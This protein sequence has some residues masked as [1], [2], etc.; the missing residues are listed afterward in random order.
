MNQNRCKKRHLD[1][2]GSIQ[3]TIGHSIQKSSR[4]TVRFGE[5]F[6]SS[7]PPRGSQKLPQCF[8]VGPFWEPFWNKNRKSGIQKG[9]PK[10]NQKNIEKVCQKASKMMPKWRDESVIAH[11]P[12]KKV[13]NEKLLVFPIENLVLGMQKARKIHTKSMQKRCWKK[14]YKNHT[15]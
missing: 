15:K 7:L 12:E 13:K 10:L 3:A 9:I 14:A 5:A 1:G 6:G 4:G 11:A 2:P 8:L